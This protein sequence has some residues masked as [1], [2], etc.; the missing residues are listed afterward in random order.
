MEAEKTGKRILAFVYDPSKKERGLL[1][2]CLGYFLQ[3][4]NTRDILNSVFVLALVPISQV[5]THSDILANQ[6]METSRWIVFE[7][8]LMPL[9]HEVIYA[10]SKEGERIVRELALNFGGANQ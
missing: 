8:D 1:G 3:N 4:K 9:K 5:F 2:H 6:S 7:P 10:N